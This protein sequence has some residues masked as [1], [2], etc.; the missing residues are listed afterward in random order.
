MKNKRNVLIFVGFFL[1]VLWYGGTWAYR[2]MYKIPRQK[3]QATIN[4]A[5]EQKNTN[6]QYLQNQQQMIER[7]NAGNYMYRSLPQPLQAGQTLYHTWLLELIAYCEFEQSVVTKGAIHT[8]RAF[9]SLPFSIRARCSLDQLSRFLYEFYWHS[10][11]HKIVL[12]QIQ[13]VDQTDLVDVVMQ[14]EGIVLPPFQAGTQPPLIN[15]LPDGFWRRLSSGLL[16]TYTEPIELRNLLQFSRG[17]VDDSDFARVTAISYVDDEP[18]VW[19]TL[20]TNDRKLIV[21]K[22]ERFRVGS[23]FAKLID[24]EETDVIFQTEGR[25]GQPPLLWIVTVGEYLKDATAIP[26][27]Y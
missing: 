22:G 10:Y 27:E 24:V 20:R 4:E 1:F 15:R 5:I 21:H 7:L 9:Y 16:S 6:E 23:F 14:I 19:I 25:A 17:G 3:I 2:N 18:E 26:P 12:V 11:L 13:P 8:G